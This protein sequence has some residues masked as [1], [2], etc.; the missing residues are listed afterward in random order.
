VIVFALAG[1]PLGL[2]YVVL[3]MIVAPPTPERAAEQTCD[4]VA[5]S[6]GLV[7]TSDSLARTEH[8]EDGGEPGTAKVDHRL[9]IHHGLRRGRAFVGSPIGDYAFSDRS[10]SSSK[11]AAERAR[12]I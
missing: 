6:R 4:E 12:A 11:Q 10:R 3:S 7:A 1:E 8:A 5:G 9:R 2:P